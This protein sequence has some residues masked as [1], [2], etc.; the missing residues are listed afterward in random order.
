MTVIDVDSHFFEP[1]DW[2]SEFPELRR[3]VPETDK[4]TLI[5]TTA[6]GE[7]L[8]SLPPQYRPN[9]YAR[10]PDVTLTDDGKLPPE[11]HALIESMVVGAVEGTVGGHNV[12]DRLTFMAEQGIDKQIVL[13]TFAFNPIAYVRREKPELTGQ[14]LRAYN[15]WAMGQFEGHTDMLI[16]A[17][18]VDLRT[19]AK[20]DVIAEMRRV[21]AG[22]SRVLL[23]WASPVDGK[24]L[25]H[26]DFDWF[27]AENE[28]LG[29]M[30][31]VH[32]GA[33]RPNIDLAW[34]NNGR[35]F[36]LSHLSYF[37]QLNQIPEIILGELL[38]AGTFQK[39]PNLRVHVAELGVDWL[40]AFVGRAERLAKLGEASGIPWPYELSPLETFQRNI[41][42][43]PLHTDPTA[44]VL[45]RVGPG[46]LVW[47]S[48]YPHPEGG[49]DAL[50]NFRDQLKDSDPQAVADFFGDTVAKDLEIGA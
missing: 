17:T 33:G 40:P 5:L 38:A 42:V 24:S 8:A 34:L 28:A 32:V 29:L 4:L 46:I 36:P 25:A 11:Q 37:S 45:E 47:S 6:F 14:I 41:R 44:S 16:P 19:M 27:W 1:L 12:Q 7:V 23:F 18:L 21:R 39:F 9:P 31:M 26:Q 10:F 30:P 35:E 3:E 13:P 48:D 22:G 2:L 43:S 20:D 49:A 15:T 50:A